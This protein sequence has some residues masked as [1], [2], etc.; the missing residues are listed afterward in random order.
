MSYIYYSFSTVHHHLFVLTPFFHIHTPFDWSWISIG[1]YIHYLVI[2]AVLHFNLYLY[3]I[4]KVVFKCVSFKARPWA[5][6]MN[7]LPFPA[8]TLPAPTPVKISPSHGLRL[9]W[10]LN[11]TLLLLPWTNC[12]SPLVE[13]PHIIL[14]SQPRIK[15]SNL[16][17]FGGQ[18]PLRNAID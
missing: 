15:L 4:Q 14:F 6:T 3:I 16:I 7:I 1:V 5:W 9:G 18:P 12:Q 11:N 10:N 8:P 17:K 13:F 2:T